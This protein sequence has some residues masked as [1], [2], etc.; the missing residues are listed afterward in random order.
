MEAGYGHPAVV[1]Q[2]P[3]QRQCE[4]VGCNAN[5]HLVKMI[6]TSYSKEPL[7]YIGN[8]YKK[9]IKTYIRRIG[10]II[11]INVILNTVHAQPKES[12]KNQNENST[13]TELEAINYRLEVAYFKENTD[14]ILGFY[15]KKFTYLPEYKPVIYD[16]QNLRQF[17]SDWFKSVNIKSFNKTIY[18][19]EDVSGYF[20]EIGNFT[21]VYSISNGAEKNYAG[22]YMIM[23]KRNTSG[24]LK[25]ISEAFGSDKNINPEDIPYAAVDVK[26]SLLLNNNMVSSKLQPEIEQFDKGVVNAVVSGDGTARANEFTQDGIYM[27][28]F[29]PT[30]IGMNMIMPYMLKTYKPN[31]ITYVKDTYREIFDIGGFVFLSGHFKVAFDDGTNKGSFE[32]NMSDLM[33]RG[34]DGRLLMYRQLAH[35]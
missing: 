24:I 10:F 9:Y 35:N 14:S 4:R 16:F 6:F 3:P 22:K 27:P 7:T 26:D 12:N 28:H 17:Y 34:K 29:D 19:V 2:I 25:I 8:S 18:S 1:F 33:K 20:L 5:K 15:N 13:K 32:G 31:V 11:I 21:L 30:Q 23:W